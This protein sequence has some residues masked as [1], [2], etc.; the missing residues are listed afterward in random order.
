MSSDPK[1]ENGITRRDFASRL[2]LAAAG[3]AVGADI[4]GTRVGAAPLVGNRVLGA[5]DRVVIAHIGIHSQGNSLKGF[6]G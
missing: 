4:F 2:G 5:N 6:A 3:V 1:D